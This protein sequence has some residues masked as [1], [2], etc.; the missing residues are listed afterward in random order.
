MSVNSITIYGELDNKDVDFACYID[1]TDRKVTKLNITKD[2]ELSMT[3]KMNGSDKF[4]FAMMNVIHFGNSKKK[5]DLCADT[6]G[7]MTGYKWN[8]TVSLETNSAVGTLVGGSNFVQ[9]LTVNFKILA[10]PSGDTL[11]VTWNFTN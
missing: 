8:E 2:S 3:L 7:A 10:T 9:N 11:S 5:I 4:D 1:K 6:V